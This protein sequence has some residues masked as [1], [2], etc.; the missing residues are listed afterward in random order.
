MVGIAFSYNS[1]ILLTEHLH[2]NGQC[3]YQANKNIELVAHLR[4]HTHTQ[5]TNIFFSHT[6]LY[7]EE[8]LALIIFEC[9][10]VMILDQ[11]HM[12]HQDL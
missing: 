11:C 8:Q 10:S 5:E 6:H 2:T 9:G 12:K 4:T 7:T 3:I 1:I